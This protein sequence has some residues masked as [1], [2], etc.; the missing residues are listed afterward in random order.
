MIDEKREMYVENAV[1]Q[2]ND[3]EL[4]SMIGT[5]DWAVEMWQMFWKYGW[6]Y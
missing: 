4:L 1:N 6:K 5:L 2:S 3:F